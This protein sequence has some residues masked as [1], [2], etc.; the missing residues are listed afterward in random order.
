[1]GSVRAHYKRPS[2]GHPKPPLQPQDL[3]RRHQPQPPPSSTATTILPV[4]TLCSHRPQQGRRTAA[5]PAT[6][7]GLRPPLPTAVP[8][9]A[10]TAHG[11]ADSAHRCT[12]DY[13]KLPSTLAPPT[14]PG[15]SHS[16]LSSTSILSTA[17]AS[18]TYDGGDRPV[19]DVV[20]SPVLRRHR[21]LGKP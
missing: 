19:R 17:A 6:I 4:A 15:S 5:G 18:I 13:S 20:N 8:P 3:R 7:A 21:K 12:A 2:C 11:R 10:A 9:T 16:A 1:M 14:Q